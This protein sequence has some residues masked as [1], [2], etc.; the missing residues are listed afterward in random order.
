[1]PRLAT[2]RN[3][4]WETLAARIP[5]A[6]LCGPALDDPSD[7]TEGRRLRRLPGNLSVALGDVDGEA[8]ILHAEQVALSSGAACASGKPGP[9]HVLAA[10]GLSDDRARS[11]LRFG[12]GRFT[13]DAQIDL[14]ASAIPAA[15]ARIRGL[16]IAPPC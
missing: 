4:L 15:V 16:P 13:D 9:S 8:V 12:L 5:G 10:L 11:T 6:E 3:R 2:L 7:C 14:A 1:M